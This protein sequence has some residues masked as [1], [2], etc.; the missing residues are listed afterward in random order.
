MKNHYFYAIYLE[1]R[2]AYQEKDFNVLEY[3][4]EENILMLERLT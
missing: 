3:I 2:P 4:A 1:R